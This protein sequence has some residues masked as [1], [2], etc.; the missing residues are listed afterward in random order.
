M[1]LSHAWPYVAGIRSSAALLYGALVGRV[2]QHPVSQQVVKE[3]VKVTT[4]CWMMVRRCVLEP[5]LSHWW[6]GVL[7]VIRVLGQAQGMQ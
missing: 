3:Q 2:K 7:G 6:I 1:Y 5:R 4:S